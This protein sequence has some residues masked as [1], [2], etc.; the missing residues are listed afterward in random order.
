MG[1]VIILAV[2]LFPAVA[3]QI[4]LTPPNSE[5]NATDTVLLTCVAYGA[6]PLNISWSREGSVL[7]NDSQ[8]ITIY[9]E[10]FEENGIT[11]TQSI[12]QICSTQ[13]DDSGVYSCS[14]DNRAGN[15]R[16]TFE[17]LVTVPGKWLCIGYYSSM[18][19]DILTA[20]ALLH[21]LTIFLFLNSKSCGFA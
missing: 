10:Q 21:N 6:L 4:V 13:I 16:S 11:F 15:S 18:H 17:L 1:S 12:L 20:T 8:R 5:V 14:A 9:E 3:P 2:C 7:M 19:I